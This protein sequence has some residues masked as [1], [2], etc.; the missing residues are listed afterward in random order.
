MPICLNASMKK[1]FALLWVVAL[2]ALLPI[3][4]RAQTISVTYNFA[5]YFGTNAQVSRLELEPLPPYPVDGSGNYRIQNRAVFTPAN[6]PSMTNGSVTTNVLVNALIKA[7]FSGPG[8]WQTRTNY[9]PASLTNQ[10]GTINAS[11]YD[12]A[13]FNVYSN[14]QLGIYF[15]GTNI[16]GSGGIVSNVA[17]ATNA[18]TAQLATNLAPNLSATNLS[19]VGGGIFNATNFT[20][21]NGPFQIIFTNFGYIIYSNGIQLTSFAQSTLFVQGQIAMTN[22]A[23]GAGFS[24]ETNAHLHVT[25]ECGTQYD[26]GTNG[27]FKIVQTNGNSFIF[28]NGSA[29]F[30]G[31]L[32]GNGGNLTNVTAS[33]VTGTLT[34]KT[35]GN[36]ASATMATNVVSGI[37]ITNAVFTS[38][39]NTSPNALTIQPNI[40]TGYSVDSKLLGSGGDGF[41]VD[42]LGNAIAQSLI[43]TNG[44]TNFGPTVFGGPIAGTNGN[45]TNT[46]NFTATGNVN[47]TG[48]GNLYV[49]AATYGTTFG[50]ISGGTVTGTLQAGTFTG[51]GSGLTNLASAATAATAATATNLVGTGPIVSI[52]S[53]TTNLVPL[54]FAASGHFTNLCQYGDSDYAGSGASAPAISGG[55]LPLPNGQIT[56][57]ATVTAPSPAIHLA[58]AFGL[59]FYNFA[60]FGA[61]TETIQEKVGN[62]GV[63]G[64]NG[65]QPNSISVICGTMNDWGQSQYLPYGTNYLNYIPQMMLAD[66][67]LVCFTYSDIHYPDRFNSVPYGAMFGSWTSQNNLW[68]PGTNNFVPTNQTFWGAAEYPWQNLY[69]DPATASGG[70]V[71]STNTGDSI[72]FSNVVGPNAVL[73]Y[74]G[75]TSNGY[76]CHGTFSVSVNGVVLTN[77][78]NYLSNWLGVQLVENN[79]S[80]ALVLTNLP[81]NACTVTVTNTGGWVAM[82]ALLWPGMRTS[83][84]MVLCPSLFDTPFGAAIPSFTNHQA[85]VAWMN[86]QILSN[87]LTLDSIGLP[88]KYVDQWSTM[89]SD[90]I[91]FNYTDFIHPNYLG[92]LA[93]Y[94]NL[95]AAITGSYAHAMLYIASGQSINPAGNGGPYTSVIGPT[96]YNATNYANTNLVNGTLFITGTNVGI[97]DANTNLIVGPITVTNWPTPFDKGWQITNSNAKYTWHSKAL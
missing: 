27:V 69:I 55:G 53:Q 83:T 48:G 32:T 9:F 30:T 28:T 58:A 29:T 15:N 47:I 56:S 75:F 70:G 66:A 94:A 50:G 96:T 59:G 84:N 67:A 61:P 91:T 95:D 6:T 13:Y 19:M 23:T 41:T 64:G 11:T 26:Y 76:G 39:G 21:T 34:N 89:Q 88:V 79:K 93:L 45:L 24:T 4:G 5:A 35:T 74:D 86:T 3:S 1:L 25:D 82:D 72:N 8:G 49:G 60:V 90:N 81:T 31:I 2:C 52:S 65:V 87:V 57:L 97:F 71:I 73:V 42:P 18:G 7:T 10:G 80:I 17:F 68:Y 85:A 51:N 46:G 77:V 22:L 16:A 37:S 36:A 62:C 92:S 33:F 38:S 12:V 14:L 78:N 44:E 63:N 54:T 20:F 43:L 40:N